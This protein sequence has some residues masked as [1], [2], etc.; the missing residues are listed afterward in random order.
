[1]ENI[2]IFETKI[3]GRPKG[4]KN[5]RNNYELKF[6]NINSGEFDTLHK[7]NTFDE[8]NTFLA[9]KNIHIQIQTLQY[10]CSGKVSNDFI[11]ILRI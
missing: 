10:I 11:K 5:R 6:L 8:I 7:C 3:K 4:S 9:S 2:E 1:M